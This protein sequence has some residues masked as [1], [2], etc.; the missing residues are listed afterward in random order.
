MCLGFRVSD[1]LYH[2]SALR[3]YPHLSAYLKAFYQHPGV[4]ETVDLDIYRLGYHS[5][6]ELRNPLGIIPIGP[7]PDFI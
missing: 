4:A 6:S 2:W 5:K 1:D 7:E 3:D